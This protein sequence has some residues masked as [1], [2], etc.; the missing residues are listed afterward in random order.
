MRHLMFIFVS[1][2]PACL[3]LLLLFGISPL[4]AAESRPKVGLVLGGGG[5]AGVAHVGVLKV[6]EKNNIPIDMIAGTSMGAIVGGL[7]ASGISADE[8]EKTV[9]SLEWL[10]LFDDSQP[11]TD[12]RFHQKELNSGFFRSFELGLKDKKLKAPSGLVT[13]QKLMFEL[14]RLFAPVNHIQ[15]FDQLPIPFR[16]VATDIETG[17]PVI[18]QQ[19]NLAQSVRASMAIPGMFSPVKIDGRLLV[20]GFVSNNVPVDVAREM[21]ADILIVVNIPTFLEEQENLDSAVAVALQAMQLMML[22]STQPQLDQMQSRDILIEPG[23]KDIG[24]LDFDR[25]EETIPLGEKAA[26]EQLL[27]LKVLAVGSGEHQVVTQERIKARMTEEGVRITRIEFNPDTGFEESL[28]RKYLGVTEGEQFDAAALQRGLESI[29]GLG[30]FDLVDHYLLKD[31][32]GGYVLKVNAVPSPTGKQ[33]LRFGIALSD[34]FEGDTEYQLGVRHI[35][36][37][38]NQQAAEWSNSLIIGD[39]LRFDS[40]YYQPIPEQDAF[41]EPHFWHEQRDFYFYDGDDRVAEVRGRAVGVSFDVGK[42]FGN[43]GEARA[44]VFYDYLKPDVTTG[45]IELELPDRIHSAGVALQYRVDT[46]DEDRIPGTGKRLQVEYTRNIEALGSDNDSDRLSVKAA[47]AWS[48]DQHR[49][50]LSAEAG[51]TFTD[52]DLLTERL[53]LGGLG[54]MSGLAE[55]QLAGNH[56]LNAGAAYLYELS[57]VGGI[58]QFYVGGTLEAGNVWGNDEDVAVNDLLL[59]GSVF[60]GANTP[61]GPAFVGIAQTEGYDTRPFL[62]VG[63]GL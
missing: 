16:A 50:I 33:R 12:Q 21:G 40:E 38:F 57:D 6:L 2:F 19:G 55:N 28:L 47:R 34:D 61:L 24:N 58:A 41:I 35:F 59:T 48:Q 46:M 22:K 56:L 45:Q 43:W 29:Y 20:D 23:I 32:Q 52:E 10:S 3:L 30:E 54:R 17:K 44:G 60:I 27:R 4:S 15:N 49:L 13:G 25:V 31:E 51:S 14:R 5:A 18:L 53:S 39:T 37:G 26:G 9:K 8:L 36:R 1:R 62:Y 42:E 63:Q 7:Y 11:R